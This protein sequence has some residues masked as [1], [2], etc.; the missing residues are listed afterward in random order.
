MPW[1]YLLIAGIFEIG[2]TL[3]LKYSAGFS[4][5]GVATQARDPSRPFSSRSQNATCTRWWASGFAFNACASSSTPATPDALSV[6]P[7]PMSTLS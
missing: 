2:W 4:R 7:W 1:I 6:A 3:G 5:P